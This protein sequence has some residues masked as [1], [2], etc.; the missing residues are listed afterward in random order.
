MSTKGKPKPP[1]KKTLAVQLRVLNGI[2]DG[3][4]IR[5]AA[6]AAGVAYNTVTNWKRTDPEFARRLAM[7]EDEGTDI[8]LAEAW[9]RAVN[10]VDKG[11]YYQG[12]LMDTVKERSDTLLIRLLEAR[13]DKFRHKA[14]VQHSGAGGMPIFQGIKRVIIKPGDVP[15]PSGVAEE[16]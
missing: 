2:A 15:E 7:A 9:D 16:E 4:T 6:I 14:D 5:N 8:L 13:S 12:V 11:I 3:M 10:G 1:V